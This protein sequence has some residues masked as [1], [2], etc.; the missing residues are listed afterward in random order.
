M[1]VAVGTDAATGAGAVGLEM[2]LNPDADGEADVAEEG[3]SATGAK[4]SWTAAVLAGT[5]A[6]ETVDGDAPNASKFG[7]KAG[8]LDV[9]VVAEAD[10]KSSKSATGAGADAGGAVEAA[11]GGALTGGRTT[12]RGAARGGCME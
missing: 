3:G 5:G 6:A 8:V 1:G 11:T 10:E 4:G 9:V 12:D 7:S 2:K